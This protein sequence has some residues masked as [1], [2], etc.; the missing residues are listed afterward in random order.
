MSVSGPRIAFF[1]AEYDDVR[2]GPGT[3]MDYLRRETA[4]GRMDLVFFSSEMAVAKTHYERRVEL[5]VD[6]PSP[7]GM[8]LQQW[9]W[10]EAMLEEHRKKP[11]DV[12]WF[13]SSM[14]AYIGAMRPRI[15]PVVAMVNDYSNAMATDLRATMQVAGFY[16]TV[17][18]FFWMWFERAT[19]QRCDMVI[20]NSRYLRDE[21]VRRYR[22]DPSRVE[23]LYKGVDLEMFSPAPDRRPLDPSRVRV[24]FLK[25]DYVRGG[26]HELV[27]ALARV[28]FA[29]ELTVAGPL[30][31]EHERIRAIAR[32][33]G[34]RG[35]LKTPGRTPRSDVPALLRDADI[36]CVPS[37]VEALGVTFMEALASGVPT[38]GS[39]AGGIPEVLDDGRAGWMVP[40]FSADAVAAALRDVVDRPDERARRTAHGLRHVQN[41]SVAQSLANFERLAAQA[42]ARGVTPAR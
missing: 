32:E 29:T 30:P 13:N 14:A 23:I 8:F 2:T 21:I 40:P 38:I 22:L 34:Y 27:A 33:A 31:A 4:R 15:A 39:T 41:F 36:V 19:V 35:E 9:M 10:H 26:F 20:V 17:T 37:R 7:P 18:R 6:L 12:V 28:P 11:F 5:P 24:V 3:F 25:N 16:R 1:T 42:A